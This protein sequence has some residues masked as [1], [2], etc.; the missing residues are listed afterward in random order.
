MATKTLDQIIKDINKECGDDIAVLGVQPRYIERIPFSSPNLNY[1]TYGGLPKN[2][3]NEFFGPENG[4]KSTTALDVI[5]NYQKMSNA[6][7]VLYVD[8]ECTFD[9]YWAT[10]LG[11]DTLKIL[12][13]SPEGMGTEKILQ[14]VEDMVDTGE[15]GLF[16]VDSV[17]AMVPNAQL[18]SDI[19]K[20]FYGGNSIALTSF[21]NK[22][23]PKLKKNDCTGILINQIREDLTSMYNSISTPGGKALKHNCSLR[24]MF[25]KG[26]YLKEVTD[27][28]F[29]ESETQSIANPQGNLVLVEI[30]KNK[31]CKPD[32][33]LA[34]YKLIYRSGVDC[35]GDTVDTAILMGYI[36]Q[37]G[38]WFDYVD[39]TT[40]EIKTDSDGTPIKW[41]GKSKV[42]KWFNENELEFQELFDKVYEGCKE[43]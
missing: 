23:V 20:K 8:V 16:V 38:A 36:N 25:T 6:K 35:I 10:A 7:K 34:Q 27:G 37:R 32:R 18:E 12:H 15:I 21:T 13:F 17:A 1:A 30:K 11:V 19:E 43:C 26:K 4:G 14:Y 28:V 31:F 22:I 24:M 33:R 3:L 41:N 39:I 5:G 42:L 2:R 40:G 29:V 9:A